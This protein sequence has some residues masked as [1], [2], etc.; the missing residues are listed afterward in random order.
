[1]PHNSSSFFTPALYRGCTLLKCSVARM[2][3][4]LH[5]DVVRARKVHRGASGD[6]HGSVGEVSASEA[7]AAPERRPSVEGLRLKAGGA[8]LLGTMS[9]CGEIFFIRK[10]EIE[11]CDKHGKY[12]SAEAQNE[13]ANQWRKYAGSQ[14]VEKRKKRETRRTGL[15]AHRVCGPCGGHL[16]ASKLYR[17]QTL[18]ATL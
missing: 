18:P 9:S 4:E 10:T 2:C 11:G 8:M 13:S 6:A 16:L 17:C 7:S 5:R 1:V 3:E 14:K 15:F 12:T